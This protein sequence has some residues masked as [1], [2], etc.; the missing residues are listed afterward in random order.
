MSVIIEIRPGVGGAEA[1]LFAGDLF[2]MYRRYAERIGWTVELL[3]AEASGDG[4]TEIVFRVKVGTSDRDVSILTGEAGTHC[5]QRVSPTDSR[6]RV[7]TSTATV[8]VLAKPT[9]R[10]FVLRDT[11]L[12]VE[13]MRGT[14]A[15]GQNRNKVESAVRVTHVP[16]GVSAICRDERGQQRNR[17]RATAVLRARLA[18]RERGMAHSATQGART[19]QIGRGERAERIRTYDVPDDVVADR[20]LGRKVRGVR[21]VL[22]GDL[23]ALL[24]IATDPIG[25]LR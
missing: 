13:T 19:R 10:E 11:D 15:G 8:A 18:A 2:S 14:G 24:G 25:P 22:R 1:A 9:E 3:N 4:F 12:R 6:K 21:R 17:E 7:H 5:I 16:T 20:R 23:S